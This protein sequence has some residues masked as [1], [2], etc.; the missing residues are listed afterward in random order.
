MRILVAYA[1]S[2]GSTGEVA[3]AIGD[4]F[5]PDADVDVFNV[6]AVENV[7][8]YDA[9]VLGSSIR[10][11]RW[12]PEALR[13]LE[14]FRSGLAERPVAYFITCLALIEETDD[15]RQTALSY[16]EPILQMTPEITPVGLGLFAGSLESERASSLPI[17]IPPHGDYRDWGKIRAW[18][19]E[20][21]PKLLKGDMAEVKRHWAAQ[22][23]KL[24]EANLMRAN[25]M[26][27]D[28]RRANLSGSNLSQAILN[29]ANLGHADLRYANLSGA[30]LSWADLTGA[31]LTNADLAGANLVWANLSRAK[32]DGV[33]LT[34]A[35]Y[36]SQTQW[37]HGQIP[38]DLGEMN[39]VSFY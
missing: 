5:R 20:I 4:V 12:L 6:K 23:T 10:A 11:G 21:F 31:D 35:H 1:S 27:A 26:G 16:L 13:F 37:P 9:I 29:G 18:A 8:K 34:G 3:Q 30:D 24:R 14:S 7:R 22:E 39:P 28:L 32:L 15:N 19:T 38:V 17:D 36:N 33:N 2:S 25:L